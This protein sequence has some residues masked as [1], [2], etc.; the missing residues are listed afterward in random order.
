MFILQIDHLGDIKLVHIA[1]Q[2]T[3]LKVQYLL[4][5]K[6]PIVKYSYSALYA[7]FSHFITVK[8]HRNN[9]VK[10]TLLLT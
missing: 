4:S 8:E 6:H 9:V 2:Q 1:L 7:V 5:K 3:M 10:Q